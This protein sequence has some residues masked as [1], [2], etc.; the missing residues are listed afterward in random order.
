M[1]LGSF[2]RCNKD[3][4]SLYRHTR[5][6]IHFLYSRWCVLQTVKW[7]FCLVK[8]I[9]RV[10]F[11]PKNWR[12]PKLLSSNST[13]T[14]GEYFPRYPI[15]SKLQ[16]LKSQVSPNTRPMAS[17]IKYFH[18]ARIFLVGFKQNIRLPVG[19]CQN[20]WLTCQMKW[21]VSTENFHPLRKGKFVLLACKYGNSSPDWSHFE[22]R[23][24]SQDFRRVLNA[25]D[26]QDKKTKMN[27][28]EGRGGKR[29][30]H[31]GIVQC[32]SSIS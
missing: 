9:W 10:F 12:N 7:A 30:A 11:Y 4:E 29:S 24:Q 2:T 16:I 26:K 14:F 23:D 8:V 19:C 22:L 17:N 31:G 21:T 18:R 20:G 28:R 13:K 5:S 6:S 3:E 1:H 27:W 32:Q 25:P 15:L